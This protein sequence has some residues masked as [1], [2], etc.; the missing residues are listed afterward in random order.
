MFIVLFMSKASKQLVQNQIKKIIRREVRRR[1]GYGVILLIAVLFLIGLF[2]PK[3]RDQIA[4]KVENS[5]P[6]ANFLQ[7]DQPL[8]SKKQSPLKE[9]IWAVVHVVDG[10]TLDVVDN[11][12]VKH[13][14]RLIGVD[15]PEVVKP[16]TPPQPFG[17]EASDFTKRVIAQ[18]GNRV[19][20][21][22]DGDQVDQYGRNLAMIYLQTPKGEI[23]LNELLLREGLAKSL[24]QYRFS[25]GAKQR[26]QTAE[27]EAKTAR[28]KIWSNT[29]KQSWF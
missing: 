25:K 14:I 22:F 19:R 6:T 17:Q 3:L 9:G 20:V 21:A 11:N 13:R 2:N 16:N 7:N 29:K 1:G 15:T 8:P 27:N 23:W 4:A 26:L 28:R 18:T 24:L 10:D 12:G 5:F